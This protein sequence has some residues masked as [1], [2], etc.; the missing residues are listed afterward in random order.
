[1]NPAEFGSLPASAC[2]LDTEGNQGPDRITKNSYDLAGQLIK[3]TEGYG[4]KDQADE[5]TYTY[6]LNGKRET[7]TDARGYKA[8]FVY[9]G[10]DR[11]TEWRFPDKTNPETV[12]ATDREL[13]QLDNNGN[14]TQLTKRDGQL[15]GY[16]Y[17]LLNRMTA[18]N[19]PGTDGDVAYTYNNLGAQTSALFS[20]TSQGI[21]NDYDALGRLLWSETNL[22]GTA[23]RLNYEY[24]PAGR[25]LRVTHPDPQPTSYYFVYDYDDASKLTAIRENGSTSLATFTYDAPSRLQQVTRPNSTAT[26]YTYDGIS[27]LWTLSHDLNLTVSDVT[28]TFGYNSASQMLTRALGNDSYAYTALTPASQ[29]YSVNGL[30]QYT[31]VAGGTYQYDDNGNLVVEP[32]SPSSTTYAYDVE[33]RLISATGG[34]AAT[35]KYDPLGRLFEIAGATT[36]RFLYDG[37]ELAAEYVS[38]NVTRRYVHGAAID[39]PIVQYEGATLATRKFLHSNHQGSIVAMSDVNGDATINRYDEYGVPQSGFAGRF[40]YTGQIWIPELQ[41]WHYKARAYSPNLGRFLQVDPVGYEDDLNLY[42]YVGNNPVGRA[43]PTGESAGCGTR[44]PDANSAG[45]SGTSLLSLTNIG[46]ELVGSRPGADNDTVT[47][48][49]NLSLDQHRYDTEG[50]NAYGFFQENAEMYRKVSKAGDEIGGLSYKM[51]DNR[52][53]HTNAIR[54]PGDRSWKIS[55]LSYAGITGGRLSGMLHSHVPRRAHSGYFSGEDFGPALSGLNSYLR[56]PKGDLRVLTPQ[57][58]RDAVRAGGEPTTGEN[59]CPI[60]LAKGKRC[61]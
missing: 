20:T 59:A 10:H 9:D 13:Y 37:D 53:A 41:L 17:D 28:Q 26:N 11:Q 30:N 40:G 48:S 18:K 32:G 5:A 44:L 24:D 38:G 35:L 56:T 60:E 22:G 46:I 1:M 42:A 43:D 52:Y 50:Q 25:R 51:N 33:N 45:C 29:S 14:R 23:R 54:L 4:T 2:T 19:V 12:S 3:V 39:D 36:T 55:E 16:T 57:A 15:I 34:K 6:T 61:F 58:G 8:M 21:S 47:I 7:L 49:A 27:R 31:S